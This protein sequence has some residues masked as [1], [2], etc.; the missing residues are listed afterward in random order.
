MHRMPSTLPGTSQV[1]GRCFL[2]YQP[3][4]LRQPCHHGDGQSP[5]T[6]PRRGDGAGEGRDSTCH[7]G[8]ASQSRR[9]QSSSRGGF[10]GSQRQSARTDR[11]RRGRE[12]GEG[13]RR[14]QVGGC[15]A[16]RRRRGRASCLLEEV[17]KIFSLCLSIGIL[18]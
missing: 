13:K 10:S 17:I 6:W 14:G 15:R 7:N 11:W 5:Q 16:G 3:N 18:L 9:S 1:T 4:R 2:S 8:P 12:R